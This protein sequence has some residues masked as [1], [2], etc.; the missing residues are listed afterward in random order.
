MPKSINSKI[1]K[2]PIKIEKTPTSIIITNPSLI[3]SPTASAISQLLFKNSGEYIIGSPHEI[4]VELKNPNKS[5][6]KTIKF[7]LSEN[8]PQAPVF[9]NIFTSPIESTE[10]QK[11]LVSLLS[12]LHSMLKLEQEIQKKRLFKALVKNYASKVK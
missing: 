8:D 5:I 12:S 3:N 6:S 4:E 10:N 1:E 11:Q 9:K 7:E 2:L